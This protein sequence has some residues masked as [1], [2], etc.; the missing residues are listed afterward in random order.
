M[1]LQLTTRRA[2]LI[3]AAALLCSLYLFGLDGMGLISK[4]EPRYADIGRAMARTGDLITPRL[5][6]R[7]W[8]E[9][10]PLLYW[11]VAAGFKAGL[12][13]ETAPRL[14][15]AILSL[16]FLV[17]Y[18]DRL[19]RLWDLRT[20][21]C[22]TGLL[23]TSAGWIA[24]SGI[25]IT[26]IPLAAFFSSA[27]L[28]S[29]EEEHPRRT[30]AAA[31]L[32]MAVLAKSLVAP[33][34]FLPVLAADR[35]R[36]REWLRPGP[37]VAF[38]A[39]ALPWNILCYLKNGREFLYV[40]F[41]QQQFGRFATTERQH[42]QKWWFYFPVLLM[43]LYPWFPLLATAG[44][45]WRDRRIK[46]LFSVA[47]FGFIFFS[48]STNKLPTYVL[49]LLPSLCVAMGVSLTK[50]E[51]PWR[52][53][54]LPLAL[55]GMVPVAG[56]VLPTAMA[57]GIRSASIPWA[58]MA[59]ACGLSAA[60]GLALVILLKQRAVPA[61]ILIAAGAFFWLKFDAYPA[62][63][64]AATAR[65]LWLATHPECMKTSDRGLAYGLNYYAGRALTQCAVLDQ[66]PA[67]V[68]R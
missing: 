27:V 9:K 46:I 24:L 29:L 26:D 5:S 1:T 50:S 16:A 36:L 67:R 57:T 41:I 28:L 53:M 34:L 21:C 47:A 31:S 52:A 39:I 33:V 51:H 6:G 55:L 58:E 32:G 59:I 65:P 54:V 64:R 56:R 68:V 44:R 43:A 25:A 10:P 11:L 38:L 7:P 40:L 3:F 62:L 48:A 19:R 13:P 18:F 20:A 8:F 61:A 45:Q 22:A 2:A 12:G 49:P 42:L 30:W 23:A 60:A 15:I 4:D 14:P 37:I 63:D 17:F 66:S 35:R